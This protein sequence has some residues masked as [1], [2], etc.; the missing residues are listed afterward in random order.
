MWNG[1]HI[2]LRVQGE[3][4]CRRLSHLTEEG[5]QTDA[6]LDASYLSDEG[7]RMGK[8]FTGATLGMAAIGS[9]ETLFADYR[10]HY[11]KG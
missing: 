10:E 9:G 5:W 3:G 2:R 6:V 1:A 8:R 11:E 7:L 4:L